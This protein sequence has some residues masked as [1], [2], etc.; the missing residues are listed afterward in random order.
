[1]EGKDFAIWIVAAVMILSPMA[2]AASTRPFRGEVAE[3]TIIAPV[4][5]TGATN[6]TVPKP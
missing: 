3:T 4:P 5:S 6:T 2:L 1:M